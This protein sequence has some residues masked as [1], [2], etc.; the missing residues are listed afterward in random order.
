MAGFSNMQLE[1][2]IGDRFS[3]ILNTSQRKMSVTE[4]LMGFL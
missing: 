1:K 4:C 3:K 2:V